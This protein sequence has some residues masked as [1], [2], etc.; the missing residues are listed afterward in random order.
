MNLCIPNGQSVIDVPATGE[1]AEL[2]PGRI[3]AQL[4]D[5]GTI[6]VVVV[7]VGGGTC[8][9]ASTRFTAGRHV[10]LVQSLVDGQQRRL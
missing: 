4:V 7:V 8:C 2:V 9:G 6:A 3:V 1:R 10:D 5:F